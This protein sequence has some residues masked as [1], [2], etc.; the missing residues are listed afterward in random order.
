MVEAA[1]G[2]HCSTPS[3]AG[4]REA[5]PAPQAEPPKPVDFVCEADVLAAR[6]EGRRICIGPRTIVTASARDAAGAS[7]ILVMA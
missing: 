3:C 4:A 6:R 1:G 5:A 7:D 2:P